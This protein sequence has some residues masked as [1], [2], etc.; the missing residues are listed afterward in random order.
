MTRPDIDEI[1]DC[2]DAEIAGA[3][4]G[5][6]LAAYFLGSEI[7]HDLALADEDIPHVTRRLHQIAE[8]YEL[9][10]G[11]PSQCLLRD[12]RVIPGGEGRAL[13]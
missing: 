10:V 8:K 2:L 11:R 3:P 12:N 1:L 6:E 5:D 9:K 7:F 4:E 13:Q